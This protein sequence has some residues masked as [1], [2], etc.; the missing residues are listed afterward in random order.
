MQ[1][2]QV[3]VCLFQTYR[4]MSCAVEM[5]S[6]HNVIALK[7]CRLIAQQQYQGQRNAQRTLGRSIDHRNSTHLTTVYAHRYSLIAQ[8]DIVGVILCCLNT[9]T[10][11]IAEL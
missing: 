3:G 8:N 1:V 11:N 5:L 10:F 6:F 2:I 4:R 7:G 9:M